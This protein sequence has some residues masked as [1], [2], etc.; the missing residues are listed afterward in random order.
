MN[1][2][3]VA[4][5]SELLT[6]YRQ[7]TNS[8]FLTKRLNE[9]GVEVIYKT[10]VGDRIEH[11]LYASRIALSRAQIVI[12]SGG[13]GPTED[14]LTRECVAEALGLELRRDHEMVAALYARA[15]TLR[16]R[17]AENNVK[18]ADYIYG[19]ELLKN[20][21]GSAPGQ[22]I[23]TSYEGQRRLII[24]LPGPPFEMEGMFNDHCFDRLKLLLP[25]EHLAT[26]EL[27]VA[28]VAESSADLRASK[29]YKEFSDIQTT[30]L[31]K[32]G[33]VQF[34]LSARAATQEEAEERV[35]KLASLLEDEFADEIFS[36]GGESLEQIVGYFLQMRG[37]T[38]SVA[39]SCT[40]GLLAERITRISGSSRYFVGGAL[41]YSDQLKREFCG[42]PPLLL[43]SDGAVSRSVAA[44]LA[45][46]IRQ[47]CKTT[48]GIGITGVAGPSGGTA[49]KPVGLVYI[50]LA[51]GKH[52]E[53]VERRFPGDR[54]RIRWYATQLALDLIRRKLR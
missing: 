14:D 43:A 4:I 25:E 5:G 3:I 33:E 29:I 36:S 54:E 53:V 42:V 46:G 6:P 15:A 49:E 40:G 31:A 18:Q 9:L 51:D 27:K 13:L 44:A 2:E 12:F 10:I 35:E 8:L 19:A 22:W 32:A 48:L 50:A 20:P 24:L 45:E 1:A 17:M 11:L 26:C 34:H 47:R 16:M 7:D 39:E 37:A 52:T 28:M 30:I 21:R 41:V 38:L 23:D